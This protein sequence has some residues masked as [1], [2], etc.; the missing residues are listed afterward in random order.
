MKSNNVF[1]V[2]SRFVSA[3]SDYADFGLRD[4]GT[5]MGGY[6]VCISNG[7]SYD[8]RYRL[9]PVVSLPSSILSETKD[10]TSEAWNLK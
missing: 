7:S 2:A 5:Y 9:R 6:N 10:A 1:W 8:T 4:A 3:N